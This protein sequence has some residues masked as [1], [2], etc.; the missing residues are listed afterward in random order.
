[1]PPGRYAPRNLLNPASQADALAALSP[2]PRRPLFRQSPGR[3][4]AW[5][6][7][8]RDAAFVCAPPSE[9]ILTR[10]SSVQNCSQ[11]STGDDLATVEGLGRQD[12]HGGSDGLGRRARTREQN[13]VVT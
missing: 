3:H 2:A 10:S 7:G 9:L 13:P 4:P 11:S 5:H 6:P 12:T 1:M 8:R